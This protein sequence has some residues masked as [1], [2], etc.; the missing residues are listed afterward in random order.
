MTKADL[1]M[2]QQEDEKAKTHYHQAVNVQSNN[3]VAVSNLRWLLREQDNNS[4]TPCAGPK[5]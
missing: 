3:V 2:S 4:A 5:K 1:L